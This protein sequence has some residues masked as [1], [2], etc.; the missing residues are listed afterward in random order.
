MG[1]SQEAYA[2]LIAAA[3][4]QKGDE[5][6]HLIGPAVKAKDVTIFEKTRSLL[7]PDFPVMIISV[8]EHAPRSFL[9]PS[10]RLLEN[11][12]YEAHS[13]GFLI[14]IRHNLIRS[15][16]CEFSVI[17]GTENLRTG[18]A[19]YELTELG[20]AFARR[21]ISPQGPVVPLKMILYSEFRS[22][23]WLPRSCISGRI[24]DERGVAS[25]S[26]DLMCEFPASNFLT[27]SRCSDA[28][29]RPTKPLFSYQSRVKLLS[30]GEVRHQN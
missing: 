5:I 24:E 15:D 29:S 7:P 28:A 10:R 26:S 14:L 4:R 18:C 8:T 6:R 11:P 12:F 2:L 1:R 17:S 30:T 21:V 27:G 9:P 25:R 22:N 20:F 19:W 16:W 23:D 13:P 3:L